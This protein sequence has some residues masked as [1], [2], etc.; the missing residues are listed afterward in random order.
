MGIAAR[1]SGHVD[2]GGIAEGTVA[3]LQSSPADLNSTGIG[4]LD[5][6]GAHIQDQV[7][8]AGS[9]QLLHGGV[10]LF[11]VRAPDAQQHLG[12]GGHSAHVGVV[13]GVSAVQDEIGT[14]ES[15]NSS[16]GGSHIGAAEDQGTAQ[17]LG[18]VHQGH[19]VI[20]RLV[21]AVVD[22]HHL[23]IHPLADTLIV[24]LGDGGDHSVLLGLVHAVAQG[25]S[26]QRLGDQGLLVT[27]EDGLAAQA[28]LADLE[29][30]HRRCSGLGQSGQSLSGHVGALL[31]GEGTRGNLHGEGHAGGVTAV[32][33]V[34]FGGKLKDVKT[35]QCHCSGPPYISA[36]TSCATVLM[37]SGCLRMTASLP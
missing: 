14:L 5:G 8:V 17:S 12:L 18:L 11:Q 19:I 13:G 32:L 24:H 21:G 4:V 26:V 31:N 28:Q 2:D 22:E 9:F 27:G 34:G 36:A 6:G 10:E 37:D 35:F 16:L 7:L 29:G 20:G 1:Q 25:H 30:L 33:A 15:L 3:V 23:H